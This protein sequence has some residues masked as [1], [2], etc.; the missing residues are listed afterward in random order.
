MNLF[1][2]RFI[3][4]ENHSDHIREIKNIISRNKLEIN[5]LTTKGINKYG[6]SWKFHLLKSFI[7]KFLPIFILIFEYNKYINWFNNF[8]SICSIWV[9]FRAI[10]Y[11]YLYM[12]KEYLI[13]ES[14]IIKNIEIL[15]SP[16][17]H[18]W[19]EKLYISIVT[20]DFYSQNTDNPFEYTSHNITYYKVK[21]FD[22]NSKTIILANNSYKYMKVFYILGLVGDKIMEQTKYRIYKI[23]NYDGRQFDEINVNTK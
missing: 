1:H 3:A 8:I 7:L 10:F 16:E 6:I 17:N 14:S 15:D 11:I 13:I 5:K 19:L 18:E 9:I 21:G 22:Y 23:G 20:I 2:Y 12:S 4:R